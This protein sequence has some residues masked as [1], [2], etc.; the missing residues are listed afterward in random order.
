M[1]DRI[2]DKNT[3]RTLLTADD[4]RKLSDY[5]LVHICVF[6][7]M[8]QRSYAVWKSLYL[9]PHRRN[10]PEEGKSQYDDK[11]RE[12][13]AEMKEALDRVF[14]FLKAAKLEVD[15]HYHV[16]RNIIDEETRR[17]GDN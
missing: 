5:Q 6:H 3:G 4:L 13:I 17:L 15:D 8:L 2:V 11:M 1:G 10:E 12:T 16:F 7:E 14:S 9:G